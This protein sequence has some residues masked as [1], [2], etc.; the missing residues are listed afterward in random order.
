MNSESL[1]HITIYLKN[2]YSE[3]NKDKYIPS[4]E[5]SE[6]EGDQIIFSQHILPEA[7]KDWCKDGEH[8]VHVSPWDI[9]IRLAALQQSHGV[10]SYV[11]SKINR[12]INHI[13]NNID[14]YI[15]I[16]VVF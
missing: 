8:I 14:R 7:F 2:D 15:G 10:T 6:D 1:V 13:E 3:N 16:V 11:E 9:R 12:I 5:V 4:Y